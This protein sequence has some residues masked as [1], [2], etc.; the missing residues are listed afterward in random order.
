MCSSDLSPFV[1][2]L[3]FLTAL[4]APRIGHLCPVRCASAPGDVMTFWFSLGTQQIPVPPIGVIEL[5]KL[6]RNLLRRKFLE[7]GV[8]IRPFGNIVY[9]TPPL[10]IDDSDLARLT[11]AMVDVVRETNA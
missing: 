4:A 3:P 2:P 7:R 9:T 10:S 6:D 8:W 11:S 1:A 5:D